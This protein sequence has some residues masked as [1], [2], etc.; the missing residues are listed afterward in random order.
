MAVWPFAKKRRR[1]DLNHDTIAS[2]AREKSPLAPYHGSI[3]TTAEGGVP[4]PRHGARSRDSHM[5]KRRPERDISSADPEKAMRTAS[6]RDPLAE[7]S[8]AH[9]NHRNR[10]KEAEIGRTA[11]AQ[12]SVGALNAQP[13]RVRTTDGGQSTYY[14]HNAASRVTI[15]SD[16]PAGLHRPPT[17]RAK[18]S[19]NGSVLA[20]RRSSKKTKKDHE[21]EAEIKHMSAPVSIPP[22][23]TSHSGGGLRRDSKKMHGGLNRHLERP[24]SD[25]SLPLPESMHSSLSE[26]SDRHAF[27]VRSLDVFAPRPTI[28]YSDS[29]RFPAGPP[30]WEPSRSSSRREKRQAIPEEEIDQRKK[31]KDLADGFDATDLRAIME[32]DQRRRDK[33]EVADAEKLRRRLQRKVEKQKEEEGTA[34]EPNLH[35]RARGRE[36]VA[37]GS[38]RRPPP[39]D[40]S[41][42]SRALDDKQDMQIDPSWLH[43]PSMEK[44]PT[45]PFLDTGDDTPLEEHEDTVIRTAKAVRLS[46]A[47]MSPPTSPQHQ[48]SSSVPQ[49]T[50]VRRE[51]TVEMSE[52]TS[53][54]DQRASESSGQFLQHGQQPP[55][56]ASRWRS[57]LRGNAARAKRN[58]ADKGRDPASE[59]A[60]TSRES[61]QRRGPPTQG[62]AGFTRRSGPPVRTMSKFREDLPELPMSPPDSRV[63]SMEPV[64]VPEKVSAADIPQDTLTYRR[65]DASGGPADP[66]SPTDPFRDRAASLNET[67]LSRHRSN[68]APSI[69]GK[70]PSPVVS[71]SLASV[72]S[73]GSWLSG[74]PP[75]RSSSQA[76][77]IRHSGSSQRKY[78]EFSDSGEEL[79]VTEDEY[80]SRLAPGPD[81]LHAAELPSAARKASSTAIGSVD[82]VED[83]DSVARP[84][85]FPTQRLGYGNVARKPT[86]VRHE[87]S[88]RSREGLLN[89]FQVGEDFPEGP[90]S[91]SSQAGESPE[92]E[93][94]SFEFNADEET[95]N[96]REGVAHARHISAGSARLLD[97]KPPSEKRLSAGSKDTHSVVSS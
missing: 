81:M 56:T 95:S 44:L 70:V 78:R 52:P 82:D 13:R 91:I 9:L 12:D 51:S 25:I 86:V 96:V 62:Q 92:G 10:S 21:R 87:N 54:L 71:Q 24:M 93:K 75:K 74:R 97:I 1:T 55:T 29:A 49:R 31:V 20:R 19:A 40:E 83:T 57:L 39:M 68:E 18:R 7:R 77:A 33:K 5:R 11:K 4:D 27:K 89:E 73:E 23:P 58:S 8:A 28:R 22:R 36:A 94:R 45:D 88:A 67:S 17:L 79:G 35:R 46:S 69:E 47:S 76:H 65:N 90:E 84:E 42:L 26:A 85:E 37:V 80:F 15:A 3:V 41:E 61:L 43:D 30:A 64:P 16:E 2:L 6:K 34:N 48:P 63:Q 66:T 50:D 72:D 14:L 60:N 53:D 38:S 59:F 32:R